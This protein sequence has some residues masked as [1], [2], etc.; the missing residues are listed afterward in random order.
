MIF[1]AQI[2]KLMIY[3][4]ENKLTVGVTDENML[5]SKKVADLIED[6]KAR[7][8]IVKTFLD[9]IRGNE[10]ENFVTSISDPFG[11]AI[12]DSNL[13]CIVGSEETKKGCEK[14]NEIRK[15]KAFQPLDIHLIK[16]VDDAFHEVDQL[17]ET[18]ISSS[19]KRIRLLGE[20][21]QPPFKPYAL[22]YIIGT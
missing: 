8:N 2:S 11:P 1:Y 17:E 15:S 7:I 21:I 10:G 22:P 5:K 9:E 18:K 3:R 16:L 4:C 14:I 19:N 6:T 13:K 20:E 12:T